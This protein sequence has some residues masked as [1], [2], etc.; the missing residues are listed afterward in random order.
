MKSF[1]QWWIKYYKF[2]V[3]AGLFFLVLEYTKHEFAGYD[4]TSAIVF[5][6]IIT[7]PIGAII[8]QVLVWVTKLLKLLFEIF[9]EYRHVRNEQ[10][11]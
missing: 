3:I 1:E 6:A 8:G 9:V 5:F 2:G 7:S 10:K 4:I 11:Q